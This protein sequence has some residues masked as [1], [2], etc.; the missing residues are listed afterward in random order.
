[1][2]YI[3]LIYVMKLKVILVLFFLKVLESEIKSEEDNY[4]VLELS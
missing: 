1:M 3:G 4:L 2:R